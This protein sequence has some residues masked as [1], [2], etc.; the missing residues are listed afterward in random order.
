MD[1]AQENPLHAALIGIGVPHPLFRIVRSIP[2]PVLMVGT[3]LFLLRSSSGQKFSEQ[4]SRKLAAATDGV[5][6]SLGAGAFCIACVFEI[7]G[8]FAWGDLSKAVCDGIG[9]GV[10]GA[11]RGF[12]HLPFELG[13]ELLDRIEVGRV[14]GKE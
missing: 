12:S 11:R 13:E 1:K 10:E 7:V 2:A 4:V 3:G 14:F 9:D 6:D 5:S 8:A